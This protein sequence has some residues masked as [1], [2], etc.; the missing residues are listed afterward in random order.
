MAIVVFDE[1]G[2]RSLEMLAIQDKQPVETLC[3]NGSSKAL[4][5]AVRLRRPK[6]DSHHLDAFSLKHVVDARGERLVAIT[7]QN[8]KGSR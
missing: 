4:R 8:R 3:P 6:P 5:D 7:N 1:G 2:D